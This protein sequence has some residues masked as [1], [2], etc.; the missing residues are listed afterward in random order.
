MVVPFLSYHTRMNQLPFQIP[1]ASFFSPTPHFFWP[2]HISCGTTF[3]VAEERITSPLPA[4][5][6]HVTFPDNKMPLYQHLSSPLSFRLCPEVFL[7]PS[8]LDLALIYHYPSRKTIPVS[9]SPLPF[10]ST[11][12]AHNSNNTSLPPQVV[13]PSLGACRHTS[14]V[15][16]HPFSLSNPTKNAGHN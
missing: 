15:A 5:P 7:S 14:R 3:S 8:S 4:S 16:V 13:A 10:F 2:P 12:P 9:S 1:S 11:P 6:N